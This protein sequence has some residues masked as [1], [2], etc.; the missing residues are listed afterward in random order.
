MSRHRD[1][2]YLRHIQDA[3]YKI[4]A[5]LRGVTR[6]TFAEDDEKQDGV[7]RQLEIVGEAA[8]G[9][10]ADFRAAHPDI[11]WRGLKDL[12][13][14]LIHGYA[15]VNVDLVWEHARRDVPQ[16]YEQIAALQRALNEEQ[17]PE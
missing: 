4:I 2:L 1:A 12:R 13:N 9:V 16:L 3:T 6:E 11:D 7:I 5:R 8:S 17:E 10:S 14:V 15:H